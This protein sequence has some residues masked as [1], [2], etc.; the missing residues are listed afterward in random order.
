MMASEKEYTT[1]PTSTQSQQKLRNSFVASQKMVDS[2]RILLFLA[3]QQDEAE[4]RQRR[5]ERGENEQIA[6][7][8]G[9]P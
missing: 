6:R 7:Q 8:V 9:E 3:A 1:S 5:H 2:D 4:E